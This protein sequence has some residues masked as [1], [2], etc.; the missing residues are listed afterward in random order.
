MVFFPNENLELYAYTETSEM[1]SYKEFKKEYVYTATVPC[2]FQSMNPNEQIKEFGE[3]REDTFKI[4]IDPDV[5]INSS[6]ILKLEGKPETYE[7]TGMVI[8]NNHLLP[9]SHLKIVVQRHRK[10][11]KTVK[12][13]EETPSTTEDTG[14]EET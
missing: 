4:Y 9:V 3:L 2:D 1:N 8:N 14:D 11:T 12:P 13:E 10:P 5:E 6:M 7:I